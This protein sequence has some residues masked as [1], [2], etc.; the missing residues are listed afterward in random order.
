MIFQSMREFM[1]K[2]RE[3]G[4]LKAV[5]GA[6]WNLEIGAITEV[7]SQMPDPPMVIFDEIK[8]YPKGFRVVSNVLESPK[9]LTLAVGLPTHLKGI[10]LANAWRERLAIFKPIPPREVSDGVVMENVLKGDQ[11]DMLKFPTPFW[12][13]LDGGR[14][15]GTGCMVVSRDP[16]EG[17]INIGSYRNQIFDKNKIGC[18]SAPQ[19]HVSI[20]MRK[21][22]KKNENC[23]IVITFGQEPATY[24][25]AAQFNSW[26]A[27]ELDIAGGIRGEP[28]E[29]IN[30]P[31]TGLPILANAEIAIEGEIPPIDVESHAEGPFGEYPGYYTEGSGKNPVIRVNAIYHRNDPIIW[32]FPPLKPPAFIRY[33]AAFSAARVWNTLNKTG[34]PGIT[35]V[36]ANEASAT[37]ITIVSIRQSY[38]GHSAQ[39][40]ALAATIPGRS[41]TRYVIVVD[42]DIDPS[43]ID[44]VMW[45]LGTRS[46]PETSINFIGGQP[47]GPIDPRMSP[48]KKQRREFFSTVAVI[49]ACKPYAWRDKFPP[50]NEFSK[51]AKAEIIKKWGSVLGIVS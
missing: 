47:C 41:V 48:E 51:E 20:M 6:D 45:A 1:E 3:T 23:P 22:W 8:G 46:D 50:N 38:P 33:G 49:D 15:I 37:F 7:A 10:G 43:D 35:G 13:D 25:P 16:D 18:H 11:V 4:D 36:W 29:F 19:R 24:L 27:S 39:V 34:L 12:H 28:V 42:D 14:F 21:Y 31:L 5:N 30:G 26:G 9:R 2:V 17:W 44:Q 32:G 40:G